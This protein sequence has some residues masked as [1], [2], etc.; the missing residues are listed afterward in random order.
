MSACANTD[1]TIEQS[2]ILLQTITVMVSTNYPPYT[3]VDYVC[4]ELGIPTEGIP[5]P[6]IKDNNWCLLTCISSCIFTNYSPTIFAYTNKSTIYSNIISCFP[7]LPEAAKACSKGGSCAGGRRDC[8]K[9]CNKW[10]TDR[11]ND[12]SKRMTF[13][14]TCLSDM[15]VAAFAVLSIISS[16]YSFRISMLSEHLMESVI[17]DIT[18]RIGAAIDWISKVW[19]ATKEMIDAAVN[20]LYTIGESDIPGHFKKAMQDAFT[21]LQGFI[22]DNIKNVGQFIEQIGEFLNDLA[23]QNWNLKDIAATMCA[24]GAQI[25]EV[26]IMV[27]WTNDRSQQVKANT[28]ACGGVTSSSVSAQVTNATEYANTI[29]MYKATVEDTI[30]NQT[31]SYSP[32]INNTLASLNVMSNGVSII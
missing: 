13:G 17:A 32:Q 6:E 14:T 8:V 27:G 28:K 4:A 20:W 25:S 23:D 30:N 26:F 18:K 24:L 21:T 29:D 3:I 12:L 1:I 22:T 5:A 10:K 16:T 7:V 19:K 31:G 9:N 15:L 2:N 11:L